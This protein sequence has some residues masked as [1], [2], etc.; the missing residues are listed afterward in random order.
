MGNLR[1]FQQL[2]WLP[3]DPLL[4]LLAVNGGI[5]VIISLA[6]AVAVLVLNIGNLRVLILNSENP[7]LPVLM[8]IAGLVI[9][10]GSVVMGSAIMMLGS[11]D[12]RRP[13]GGLRQKLQAGNSVNAHVLQPIAVRPKR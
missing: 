4:R 7:V 13:G 12:D 9:T 10:L 6:F 3:R 8:L 11:S 2:K 5:G 1:E